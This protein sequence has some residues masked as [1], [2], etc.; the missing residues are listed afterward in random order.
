MHIVSCPALRGASPETCR[1][2]SGGE[3][4][5]GDAAR[6]HRA[7]SGKP[8]RVDAAPAG[9][10]RN[11]APGRPRPAVRRHYDRLPTA[12]RSKGLH[13]AATKERWP[14]LRIGD[15]NRSLVAVRKY[16]PEGLQERRLNSPD[17]ASLSGCGAPGG[18]FLRSQ[19]GRRRLRTVSRAAS[20]VAQER[21]RKRSAFP[22]AP[23]P[24]GEPR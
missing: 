13:A 21:D 14:L 12:L 23:L 15:W 20:P 9:G 6:L 4:R 16:G 10:A 19:G 5:A 7:G 18:A 1:G 22:G 24:S 11:Q 2:R 17:C 8:G 3:G